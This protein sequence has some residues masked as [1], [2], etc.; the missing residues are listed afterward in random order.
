MSKELE[1]KAREIADGWQMMSAKGM[2]IGDCL[3]G[4]AKEALQLKQKEV[5][6][7]KP[8]YDG[9]IDQC[10]VNHL[11]EQDTPYNTI[12]MLCCWEADIALDPKVSERVAELHDKIAS[13]QER[14]NELEDKLCH[15][16]ALIVIND[17]KRQLK[18]RTETVNRKVLALKN[19]KRERQALQERIKELESD[20]KIRVGD[21]VIYRD[22]PNAGW[23]QVVS[24]QSDFP[25]IEPLAHLVDEYGNTGTKPLRRLVKSNSPHLFAKKPNNRTTEKPKFGTPTTEEKRDIG[26]NDPDRGCDYDC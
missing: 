6:K 19:L 10:A 25:S 20:N 12:N 8:Y 4:C 7:Y 17:L 2:T 26:H 1:Q 5:D 21:Y 14:I 9:V 13:L 24:I 18:T 15:K 11:P 3:N 23:S 22:F 16:G